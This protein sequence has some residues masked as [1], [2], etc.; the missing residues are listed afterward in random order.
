MCTSPTPYRSPPA[1]REK[2]WSLQRNVRISWLAA[3][4]LPRNVRYYSLAA[5]TTRENT[6]K[7]LRPFYDIL[8]KVDPINDGQVLCS[9]AII[10]GSVLLGYPNADHFAVTMPI[11]ARKSPLLAALADKN[12]YPRAAL[13]EAA[14]RFVEEDLARSR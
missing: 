13:L 8:S 12:D 2:T 10:P 6:S 9:D 4:S 7:M 5:F 11:S 14:L 3:H 1:R